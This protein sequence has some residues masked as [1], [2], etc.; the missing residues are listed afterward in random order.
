MAIGIS[1]LV[2]YA[3][4]LMLGSRE[5]SG[6]TV[7]FLNAVLVGQPKITQVTFLNPILDKKSDTTNCRFWIFW[8]RTNRDGV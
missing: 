7:H 3:F 2:D 4:K 1:P 5:H 6:I 8:P